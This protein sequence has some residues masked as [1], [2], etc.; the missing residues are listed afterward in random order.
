MLLPAVTAAVSI[1]VTPSS[2][3]IQTLVQN[4]GSL[5]GYLFYLLAGLPV[6]FYQIMLTFNNYS[7]KRSTKMKKALLVIDVQNEYIDGKLPVTYPAGSLDNILKVM[8]AAIERKVPVVVVQHNSIQENAQ[9]FVKGTHGWE[10]YIEIANRPYDVLIEK[11]LPGS[12]TGTNLE[13]WIRLNGIDTITICGFMTQMCCDTT[14]RQAFHMG[15]N[16]EF[17]SDATGTLTIR[18]YAGEIKDEELHRAILVTQAM[19]FSKVISSGDWI[20]GLQES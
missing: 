19:R 9:T 11:N 12:F 14:S 16:V 1:A 4:R 10:L 5:A 18:N 17:L 8:D 3:K 2:C 15:L 20:N 6:C 7:I 13:D